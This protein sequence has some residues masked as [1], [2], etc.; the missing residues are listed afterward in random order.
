MLRLITKFIL[1]VIWLETS[2]N[3]DDRANY[4]NCDDD[5]S[6]ADDA[7]GDDAMNKCSRTRLF[8]FSTL[9][10]G[11]RPARAELPPGTT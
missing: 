9:S 4:Y 5:A 10:F 3:D 2:E 8:I 6:D 1:F 11:F 7:D